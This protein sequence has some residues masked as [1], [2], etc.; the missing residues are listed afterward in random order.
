MEMDLLEKENKKFDVIDVY[1]VKKWTKLSH[2]TKISDFCFLEKE[3]A[4]NFIHEHNLNYKTKNYPKIGIYPD[5]KFKKA[6]TFDDGKTVHI[7]PDA[8]TIMT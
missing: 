2:E 4:E 7:L 8:E 6:I 5:I 1:V 3:L